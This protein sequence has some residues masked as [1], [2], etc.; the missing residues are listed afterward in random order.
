MAKKPITIPSAKALAIAFDNMHQFKDWVD[1]LSIYDA[2]YWKNEFREEQMYE[3]CSILRDA[4]NYK[5][6]IER[7]KNIIDD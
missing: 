6:I 7:N 4:I 2:I 3:Y 5:Y 1:D